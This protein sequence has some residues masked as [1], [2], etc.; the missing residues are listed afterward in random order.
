MNLSTMIIEFGSTEYDETVKLR[1]KILR[2][3]LNMEFTIEQLEAEYADTHLACTDES[4]KIVGC[5]ILTKKSDNVVKMRQVAVEDSLQ[6]KG[7][8]KI[9]VSFCEEVASYNQYK[10]IELNARLSAVPFYEK[11]GY[12]KQGDEFFEVGIPHYFMFKKL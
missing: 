6:G 4:G 11:L 1:T 7:I 9:L 8:G 12:T 10:T 5:L 3:P 2:E